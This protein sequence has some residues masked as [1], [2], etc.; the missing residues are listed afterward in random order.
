MVW[1]PAKV[2]AKMCAAT[3]R[4]EQEPPLLQPR[5]KFSWFALSVSFFAREKIGF[6][7]PRI[8]FVSGLAPQVGRHG[9]ESR[10]FQRRELMP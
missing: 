9:Q 8:D 6:G 4:A 1:A 10:D 5:Y 2:M 3:A 7:E